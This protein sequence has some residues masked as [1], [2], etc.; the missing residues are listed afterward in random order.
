LKGQEGVLLWDARG[1][2][3]SRPMGKEFSISLLV[4]DILAIMNKE[5]IHKATFVGQSMGGNSTRNG[6]FPL[7]YVWNQKNYHY[8]QEDLAEAR[9]VITG[10]FPSIE[11]SYTKLKAV[12]LKEHF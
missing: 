2:G 9:N 1:H 3:L 11:S 7:E 4:D 6:L 10:L 5:G 8:A 12:V